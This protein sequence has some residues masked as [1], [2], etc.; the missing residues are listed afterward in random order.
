MMSGLRTVQSLPL[1]LGFHTGFLSADP[2]LTICKETQPTVDF[3]H[4]HKDYPT[5]KLGDPLVNHRT[6]DHKYQGILKTAIHTHTH[7]HRSQV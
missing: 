2:A 7:T 1:T 3:V 5:K 6:V 4:G